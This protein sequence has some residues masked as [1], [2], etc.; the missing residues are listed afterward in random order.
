[1][2]KKLKRIGLILSVA[3]LGVVT[4]VSVLASSPRE[5]ADVGA[6]T[7]QTDRRIYVY[8]EGGWDNAG[9]M[10]IHYWGGDEGTTWETCPE[11]TNVVS[12]YWQGLF[13]YDVPTDVTHFLVKD[14]SGNV[15]NSKAS[16]QSANI[17]IA[18]LFPSE[19]SE[20]Y[21][22]ATVK[23][24]VEDTASRVAD[25]ADNAPMS[26]LQA[27]AVLNHI[28]SCS[29]S[30]AGGHNAWPQLNDLFISPSTL[31]GSTVVTD[32]FGDDTTIAAKTAYLQARYN[33]D[34]SS[35]AY[36]IGYFDNKASLPLIIGIALIG[37]T[38]IAGLYILK[39]KN[40]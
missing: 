20:D 9:H 12:D 27:A 14:Q 2:N 11:M 34:Q 35:S 6:V 8:L 3:A 17:L 28:D 5:V 19:D 10:F 36:S 7:V 32:N 30:Y 37:I 16:N 29:T 4:G 21:K 25:V 15:S 13:Y 26:S 33:A 1:M 22:V 31:D 40:T 24:W 18:D 38:S 23:A 39:R